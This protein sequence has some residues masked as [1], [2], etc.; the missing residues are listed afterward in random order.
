VDGLQITS[1]DASGHR[2]LTLAGELDLATA[3]RLA[4][5]L[6]EPGDGDQVVLDIGEL[7]FI[8]SAGL[9]VLARAAVRLG[10][11][12]VRIRLARPS[13]TLRRMVEVTGLQQALDLVD[14]LP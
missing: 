12:G 7:R 4:E 8:D 9:G 1:S 11:R 3:D 13:A 6:A 10:E 5:A 2:V 14:E